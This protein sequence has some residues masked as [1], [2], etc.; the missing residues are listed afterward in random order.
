MAKSLE[1]LGKDLRGER[2]TMPLVMPRPCN[3][4]SLKKISVAKILSS[5]EFLELLP[6]SVILSQ[7]HCTSSSLQDFLKIYITP[8]TLCVS[9]RLV[10]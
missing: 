2:N 8:N 5:I 7:T 1:G 4:C 10:L 6:E 9:Y 3:G